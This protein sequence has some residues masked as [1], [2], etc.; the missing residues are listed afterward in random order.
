M[1]SVKPSSHNIEVT[2]TVIFTATADGVGLQD[3]TYQWI[4]NG[5]FIP[6]QNRTTLTITNIME[7]DGGNYSCLVTNIYGNTMLSN[8][9]TLIVSS[10]FH[11]YSY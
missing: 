11:S 9:V 1:V 2:R 5:S 7:S 3:F 6:K 8:V 10:K 4:H